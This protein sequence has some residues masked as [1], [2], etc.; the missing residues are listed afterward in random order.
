MPNLV[1]TGDCSPDFDACPFPSPLPND[2]K[3]H[4]IL[5]IYYR[6]IKK[7]PTELETE[8]QDRKSA[9]MQLYEALRRFTHRGYA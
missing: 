3:M 8:T 9:K 7:T 1:F 4:T 5:R 2:V 6:V